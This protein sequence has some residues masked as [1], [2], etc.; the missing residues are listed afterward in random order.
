MLGGATWVSIT[1]RR[2]LPN[3]GWPAN[4]SRNEMHEQALALATHARDGAV[5]DEQRQGA[6]RMVAY[7]EEAGGLRP[8]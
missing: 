7:I 5:D 3:S 2:S 6:E 4:L 8:E 1:R